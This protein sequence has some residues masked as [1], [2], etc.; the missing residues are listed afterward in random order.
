VGNSSETML[1]GATVERGQ[2]RA[3]DFAVLRALCEPLVFGESEEPSSNEQIAAQ[4]ILSEEG[5]KRCLT[6]LFV[7]F[8]VTE[9]PK[10]RR[11]ARHAIATG[12][13]SRGDYPTS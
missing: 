3:N 8:S 2:L 9:K 5:V 10:R 11:L 7:T 1:A 6:R 4:V 12:L 13:I